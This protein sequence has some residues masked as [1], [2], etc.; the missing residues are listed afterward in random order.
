MSFTMADSSPGSK[1]V[2]IGYVSGVSVLAGWTK[3]FKW[4]M[5]MCVCSVLQGK[6][7]WNNV[8]F[9]FCRPSNL[10]SIVIYNLIFQRKHCFC[11]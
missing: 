6:F 5:K 3:K 1:F 4:L 2:Y 8:V 9:V 10:S 11:F 7:E